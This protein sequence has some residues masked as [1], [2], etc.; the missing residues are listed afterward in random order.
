MNAR[1]WPC[2]SVNLSVMRFVSRQNVRVPSVAR[3]GTIVTRVGRYPRIR[4]RRCPFLFARSVGSTE[5]DVLDFRLAEAWS[6]P[7]PRERAHLIVGEPSP[8]VSAEGKE[9]PLQLRS[10][11]VGPCGPFAGRGALKKTTQDY[12][13]WSLSSKHHLSESSDRPLGAIAPDVGPVDSLRISRDP[14]SLRATNET[15]RHC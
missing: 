12:P 5:Q 13:T 1:Y 15:L 7:Y 9:E 10:H 14:L 6:S 8:C 4:F 2:F 3:Q 11:A